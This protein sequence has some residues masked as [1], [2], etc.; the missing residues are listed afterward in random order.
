MQ[1]ETRMALKRVAEFIKGGFVSRS[2]G[3]NE[4]GYD[5]IY[6]RFF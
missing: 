6:V 2:L 3:C 5:D 1:K 4:S